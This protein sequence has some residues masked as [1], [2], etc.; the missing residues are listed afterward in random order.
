MNNAKIFED[1]ETAA[2][3]LAQQA[4]KQAE[5]HAAPPYPKVFEVF[6]WHLSGGYP[7][8][9]AAV[10]E[11]VGSHGKL[12]LESVGR[13]HDAYL[14]DGKLASE[15]SNIGSKLEESLDDLKYTIAD[16][17]D[18]GAKFGDELEDLSTRLETTED[19]SE[20]RRIT[21]AL[22]LKTAEHLNA[23][24]RMRQGVERQAGEIE[25]LKNEVEALRDEAFL[26]HLTKVHNRRSFEIALQREFSLAEG[27][28]SPLSMILCD[29]DHFKAFNDR[30]GHPAGDKLLRKVGE[31]FKKNTKRKDIV[32]RIGGEEFA[33]VL[34][35]TSDRGA[36]ALAEYLRECVRALRIVDSAKGGTL[37][38]VTA[39]FGVSVLQ[40]GDTPETLVE[41]ADKLLY[42]AKGAGRNRVV[43][44]ES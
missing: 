21:G 10:D 1:G 22:K 6:Y 41:R 29:L 13:L 36:V 37:S 20:C 35:T 5:M 39:S 34:P 30:H 40:P 18:G 27:N 43:R 33:I 19:L 24:Q 23:L 25:A 38:R 16:G 7:D 31:I 8:L 26:D 9:S 11:I 15:F 4:L 28:G 14:G 12:D 44:S 3:H 42:K 17:F 32:A 2:S